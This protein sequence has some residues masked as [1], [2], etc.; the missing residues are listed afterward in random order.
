MGTFRV[1][2]A[3]LEV[4]DASKLGHEMTT[5]P[6][7][8]VP[9]ALKSVSLMVVRGGV[10]PS[11]ELG[12][13][14]HSTRTHSRHNRRRNI[15]PPGKP[16]I[17]AP[18]YSRPARARKLTFAPSR[19]NFRR[20]KDFGRE[21]ISGRSVTRPAGIPRPHRDE[22]RREQARCHRLADNFQRSRPRCA[23]R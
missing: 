17:P 16:R 19:V 13:K 5:T 1:S 21:E 4:S 10:A 7:N 22:G 8:K 12:S 18:G 23:Q 15:R 11:F 6:L 2:A 14:V 3:T 9:S 20:G